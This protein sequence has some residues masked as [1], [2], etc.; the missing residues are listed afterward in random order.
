MHAIDSQQR[1]SENLQ[2][3]NEPVEKED[4]TLKEKY[5]KALLERKA[6]EDEVDKIKSKLSSLMELTKKR[7]NEI[8]QKKVEIE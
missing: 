6:A 1:I 2:A 7:V 5:E 8:E 3:D 4:N